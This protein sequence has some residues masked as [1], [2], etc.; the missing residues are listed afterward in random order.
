M[1]IE[2]VPSVPHDLNEP[3]GMLASRDTEALMGIQITC[4]NFHN[5]MALSELIIFK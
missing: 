4:V 2:S 1:S 5:E 3:M